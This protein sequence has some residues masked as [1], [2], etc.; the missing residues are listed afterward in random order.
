MPPRQILFLCTGNF[1]RSRFAEELFNHLA[2]KKHLE[3]AAASRGLAQDFWGLRNFGFISKYALQELGKRGI[4]PKLR[5]PR[6]LKAG[7]AK[8]YQLV[9]ALDQAEHQPL[10]ETYYPEI[11]A[12]TYW[13]IKDL[14]D[15]TS[16]SALG[17]IEVKVNELIVKLAAEKH[18]V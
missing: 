13:D 10:I 2:R 6:K 15:E 9:I 18:S 14:G 17:R 11:T 3:W 12:V 4:Q 8:G 1:Y 5:F 7:E 16:E